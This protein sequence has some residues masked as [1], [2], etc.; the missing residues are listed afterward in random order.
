[1]QT[2]ITRVGYAHHKTIRVIPAEAGI[3]EG[4]VGCLIALL[5]TP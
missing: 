4:A 5:S 3:Q 2:P 1:M